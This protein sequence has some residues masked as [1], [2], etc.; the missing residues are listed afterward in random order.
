MSGGGGLLLHRKNPHPT[1]THPSHPQDA[2]DTWAHQALPDECEAFSC[3]CLGPVPPSM[4]LDDETTSR[5]L[6]LSPRDAQRPRREEASGGQVGPYGPSG[7]CQPGPSLIAPLTG[8]LHARAHARTQG[9]SG[10][11]AAPRDPS[12]PAPSPC[13]A[14]FQSASHSAARNTKRGESGL[15]RSIRNA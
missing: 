13:E 8:A 7:F 4:K 15:E 9:R 14:V 12:D 3:A 2:A 6:R 10:W 5:N 1:P 11:T